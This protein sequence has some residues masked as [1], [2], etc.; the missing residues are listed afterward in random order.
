[1]K[2]EEL[3]ELLDDVGHDLGFI[4]E[5]LFRHRL[6]FGCWLSLSR[7]FISAWSLKKLSKECC[8]WAK[9]SMHLLGNPSHFVISFPDFNK[10]FLG[11]LV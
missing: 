4:D 6:G 7:R 5:R 2:P 1:L 11:L 9:E 10:S 3:C 8:N